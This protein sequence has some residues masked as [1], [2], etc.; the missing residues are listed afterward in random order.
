MG[1]TIR[2]KIV[3]LDANGAQLPTLMEQNAEIVGLPVPPN[4]STRMELP[5]MTPDSLGTF[6]LS[7]S[8]E[9]IGVDGGVRSRG[10]PVPF[11]KLTVKERLL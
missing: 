7:L 9:I 6:T 4:G 11:G 1:L 2:F 5:Y 8:T 3:V 10:K